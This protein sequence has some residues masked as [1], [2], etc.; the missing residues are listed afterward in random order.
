MYATS[1]SPHTPKVYNM[2]LDGPV[3]V[4]IIKPID[5]D[6]FEDDALSSICYISSR[7]EVIWD[8][9]LAG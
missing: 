3:I 4:H 5:A 2:V 9:S 6:T 1:K 7:I 8:I